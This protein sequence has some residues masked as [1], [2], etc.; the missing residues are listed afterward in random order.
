MNN[1]KILQNQ[2]DLMECLSY[3]MTIFVI[4]WIPYSVHK[5]STLVRQ[6]QNTS[7]L[8]TALDPDVLNLLC[9]CHT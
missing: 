9:S 6:I 8:K 3:R 5:Q 1:K 7:L 4:Y 2:E